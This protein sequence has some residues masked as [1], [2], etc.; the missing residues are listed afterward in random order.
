MTMHACQWRSCR[1]QACLEVYEAGVHVNGHRPAQ[2]CEDDNFVRQ[3]QLLVLGSPASMQ[4]P[5]NFLQYPT[6]C[7]IFCCTL[8]VLGTN[9]GPTD[10]LLFTSNQIV[11]MHILSEN[12]HH[13]MSRENNA[14]TC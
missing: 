12:L 5:E 13:I 14:V 6:C 11:N 2:T 10:R 4:P 1:E 8:D 7:D 3:R 9:G